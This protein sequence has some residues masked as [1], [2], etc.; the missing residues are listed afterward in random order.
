MYDY[1]LPL[2]N[3][4]ASM[5][6]QKL[7]DFTFSRGAPWSG[8]LICHVIISLTAPRVE[9]SKLSENVKIDPAASRG[10]ENAGAATRWENRQAF[11]NVE[12]SNTMKEDGSDA[13]M[14]I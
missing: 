12:R 11:S 10:S 9:G 5:L 3:D 14:Q 7:L 1:T 4:F 8:W 6:L 2:F 13:N